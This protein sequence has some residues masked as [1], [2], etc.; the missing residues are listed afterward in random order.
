[1][2][3]PRR[4]R[5]FAIAKFLASRSHFPPQFEVIDIICESRLVGKTRLPHHQSSIACSVLER[6]R[7]HGHPWFW[8][9]FHRIVR[10]VTE[11]VSS[12]ILYQCTMGGSTSLVRL[13]S[14]LPVQSSSWSWLACQHSRASGMSDNTCGITILHGTADMEPPTLD[15]ARLWWHEVDGGDVLS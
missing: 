2:R 7:P 14:A 11:N 12:C 6:T 15:S 13:S 3:S 1:M 10:S 9:M 5:R 8:H 4:R